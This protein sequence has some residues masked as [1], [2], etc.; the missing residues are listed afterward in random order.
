MTFKLLAAFTLMTSAAIHLHA[1]AAEGVSYPAGALYNDSYFAAKKIAPMSYKNL[2]LAHLSTRFREYGPIDQPFTDEV[3]KFLGFTVPEFN[4][5]YHARKLS[6]MRK[7]T[8]SDATIIE[9]FRPQ[10]TA[11]FPTSELYLHVPLSL[12]IVKDGRV[13]TEYKDAANGFEG[14]YKLDRYSVESLEEFAN[15]EHAW[16]IVLDPAYFVITVPYAK[17]EF[18]RE[19]YD[20]ISLNRPLKKTYRARLVM[21]I[22]GCKSVGASGVIICTPQLTSYQLFA[23]ENIGEASLVKGASVRLEQ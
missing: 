7:E 20:A 2:V 13:A 1:S 22:T 8:E 4:R 16:S 10:V 6:G 23:G 15:A 14:R 21:K 11:A 17:T 12:G 19:V 9:K 5:I 18:Q 3:Q